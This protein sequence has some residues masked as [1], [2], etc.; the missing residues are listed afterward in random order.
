MLGAGLLYFVLYLFQPAA[1]FKS[2]SFTKHCVGNPLE[3]THDSDRLEIIQECVFFSGLIVSKD[4]GKKQQEVNDLDLRYLV[5]PN[6][7]YIRFLNDINNKNGG[8]QV[9]VV[10]AHRSFVKEAN[11][12]DNINVIGTLVFDKEHGWN[13][14][15]PATYI[16]VI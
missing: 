8:L 4:D 15:H 2:S 6:P 16:K 1:I 11:V 14:I 13:E 9:E 5:K 3:H 7:S 12:G 10:P